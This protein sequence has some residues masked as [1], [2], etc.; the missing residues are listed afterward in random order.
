MAGIF[1]GFVIRNS[2]TADYNGGYKPATTEFNE[3]DYFTDDVLN[4]DKV[5][6]NED[7]KS[8]GN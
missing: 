7:N 8:E 4:K 2:E 3:S 5:K 1:I 6:N